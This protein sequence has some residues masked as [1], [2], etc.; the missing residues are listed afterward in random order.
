[1]GVRMG[2]K[3]GRS[4]EERGREMA[5]KGKMVGCKG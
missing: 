2:K 1:M 4:W 5:Q 3:K